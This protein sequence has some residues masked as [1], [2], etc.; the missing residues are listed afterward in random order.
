MSMKILFDLILK[1]KPDNNLLKIY[2][3]SYTNATQLQE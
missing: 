3:L 1:D 2:F